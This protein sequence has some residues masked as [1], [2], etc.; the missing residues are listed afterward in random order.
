MIEEF[1]NFKPVISK[2]AFIHPTA[3]IIGRVVIED[4][5]SIWPNVVIRG[6]VEEIRIMKNSNVQDN[7]VLHPNRNKPV[8]I[9]ENVT[10]GHCAVVHGS[11][12]GN[13]SLIAMNSTVIDSVVGENCIIGA[14]CVVTPDSNIP[15]GSLVLGVPFKIVRKLSDREIESLMKSFKDYIELSSIYKKL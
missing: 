9:G 1:N 3:V 13:N 11:V 2:T 7:S 5:V 8:I 15:S 14:G 4:N 12:I 10:I 6:D